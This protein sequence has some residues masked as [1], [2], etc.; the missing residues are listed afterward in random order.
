MQRFYLPQP[1]D[2]KLVIQ[3]SS[4]VHQISIVLRSRLGETFAFFD[5]KNSEDVI[6]ELTQIMKKELIFERKESVKKSISAK[7]IALYQA[8]PNKL[9]KLEYI[10][11]KWTEVGISHFTFF[12]SDRSQ[13]LILSPQKEDRLKKICIE[14]VEQ[15][16]R[17]IIP[18]VQFIDK[19]GKI[20]GETLYFHPSSDTQSL[21]E[22]NS[23][24]SSLSVLVWPEWG[25]SDEEVQRFDSAWYKK[26]SLG[27]FILRAETVG[28]VVGFYL[29]QR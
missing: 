24:L 11:Q 20:K 10:I 17:N 14:A 25:W 7:N 8:L 26:V 28:V 16:G 13:K 27:D 15:S 12:R 5:G 4:L 21:K 2:S 6:Y 9:E 23:S 1:F 18:V 29:N 19:I 3:D 22:I